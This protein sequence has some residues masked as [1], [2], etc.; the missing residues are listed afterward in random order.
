MEPT[1][2]SE[3]VKVREE[4]DCLV[5][6]R[7]SFDWISVYPAQAIAANQ[8]RFVALHI[9]ELGGKNYKQDMP[10]VEQFVAYA[11]AFDFGA[12]V[13]LTFHNRRLFDAVKQLGYTALYHALDNDLSDLSKFTVLTR[14]RLVL[15]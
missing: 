8:P 1:W 7:E 2:I 14:V 3:F 11:F 4:I 9:Q 12:F 6:N 5:R 13:V 10:L 15:M